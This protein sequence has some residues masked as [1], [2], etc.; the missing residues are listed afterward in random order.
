MAA[1]QGLPT[2]F[3]GWSELVV[4]YLSY[5]EEISPFKVGNIQKLISDVSKDAYVPLP[6]PVAVAP[7][8]AAFPPPL[9]TQPVEQRGQLALGACSLSR[10]L[11]SSGVTHG[12]RERARMREEAGGKGGHGVAW[13]RACVIIM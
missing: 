5:V 2:D 9:Q 1:W 10:P 4:K 12:H 6:V 13:M 11:V 7:L 3:Q 8:R